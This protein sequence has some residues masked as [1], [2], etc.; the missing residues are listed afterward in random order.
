MSGLP[1]RVFSRRGL[2]RQFSC[3]A[4][5]VPRFFGESGGGVES[6]ERWVY[7]SFNL[8]VPDQVR[9]L[10]ELMRESASLGYTHILLTDSKFSRLQELDERYFGHVSEVRELSAELGLKLILAVFPVGYSNSLLAQNPNLAEGLPVRGSVFEVRGG[11]AQ[12]IPDPSVSLP[13]VTDRAAWNFVDESLFVDGAALCTEDPR[14]GNCRVMKSVSVSPWRHYHIS[15][16]MKTENFRGQPQIQVLESASGRRLCFTN[17]RTE[18]TQDWTVQHVTF[19]SLGN[20]GVNVYV[21]VW[22]PGVGR[23]WMA[24]VSMEECGLLNVLRRDGAPFEV[25]L[26]DAAGTLLREG[27]DF[28][29]V[30]DPRLGVVPYAGEYEVYHEE[31]V[32]R[33]KGSWRDGTRL[34]LSWYHPHVI[35][36]EQVCGCATE[37]AFQELL[38]GQAA[39]MERLFPQSDRMM[40]H[41][42]WR[43]MGWD[44]SFRRTGFTPGEAVAENVRFCIRQLQSL[45]SDRRIAVWSDMFDPHH[46]AIDHY[47]L[48]NGDLSGSWEG[49]SREVVIVNWNFGLREESLK[50]FADRGHRQVLAGY[51]DTDAGQVGK[52]LRTVKEQ[53][54][55]GVIGAMYT[56]WKQDYSQLREFAE[57]ISQSNR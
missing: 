44:E 47:Y 2:L 45:D 55:A 36:D 17:L 32:L 25:R 29:P 40:S 15:V 28:E 9:R 14:S 34:R 37:P 11:V 51:Y 52:W 41:D 22:G 57:V 27:V 38:K 56:T 8:L 49:L 54:T 19:N 33:M 43:V 46:N 6:F 24:D 7:A 5:V 20:T 39:A 4:A 50:F 12:V 23:L 26:D 18:R 48:V 13:S 10:A 31:P 30:M 1:G 21:G 3:G 16:R 35:H 42:E 53:G